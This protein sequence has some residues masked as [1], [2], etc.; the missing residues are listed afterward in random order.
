[1]I[2]YCIAQKEHLP[3]ILELYRQLLPEEEIIDINKA[4]EIWKNIENNNIKYFIAIE[5]NKIISSCYLAI[6][7]NLTRNGKSNG[8]IENVI[9]DESYRNKGI[10]KKLINM[11]IEYG[12]QNNCYKIVLLCNIGNTEAHRFYEKCGFN[13]KSKKAFE[14]RD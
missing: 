9:T 7:P 8:F 5:N 13:G 11:A 12:K 10:G 4:N 3:N 1:M 6:I 2:N 14:I